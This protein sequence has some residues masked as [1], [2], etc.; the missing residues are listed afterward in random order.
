MKTKV[1]RYAEV[2]LPPGTDPVT[3]EDRGARTRRY[4][5]WCRELER[6]R[7]KNF[8]DRACC[9]EAVVDDAGNVIKVNYSANRHL[10]EVK[11]FLKEGIVGGEAIAKGIE[12]QIARRAPTGAMTEKLNEMQQMMAEA[13]ALISE[14]SSE[15]EKLREDLK[16]AKG[17]GK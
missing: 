15:I 13:R 7:I 4:T 17:G 5:E 12:D 16:K 8:K 9:V 6:A 11:R 10:S 2:F 3:G 14:Q 1:I